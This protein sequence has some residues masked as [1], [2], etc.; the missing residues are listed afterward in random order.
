M[1]T[2]I[3]LDIDDRVRVALARTIDSL[4]SIAPNMK[5]VDPSRIHLTLN[6]IGEIAPE[7]TVDISAALSSITARCSPFELT[8]RGMGVFES[9]GKVRVIWTGIHD[10]AG[11][12][13]ALHNDVTSALDELGYPPESRPFS[14]HLTLARS[15]VPKPMPLL[16]KEIEDKSE[17]ELGSVSVESIVLYE[18]MLDRLGPTYQAISRHELIGE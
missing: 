8:V 16:M 10:E 13:E 4:K 5:W 1:R 12:L 3:A 9:R 17:I 15:R 18:S 14:P 6:F 11:R 7:A 2:F